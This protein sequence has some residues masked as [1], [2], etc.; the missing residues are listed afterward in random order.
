MSQKKTNDIHILSYKKQIDDDNLRVQMN[1]DDIKREWQEMSQ[2]IA[3][4][5]KELKEKDKELKE[6]NKELKEKRKLNAELLR[7]FE[8]L[9]K[10]VKEI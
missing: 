3:E 9:K 10:Q 7:E 6:K 2:K 8:K 1:I 5:D 4:K